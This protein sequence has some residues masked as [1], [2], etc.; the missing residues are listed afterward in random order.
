MPHQSAS[1]R[2][3]VSSKSNLAA[4]FFRYG[5]D[6]ETRLSFWPAQLHLSIKS[7]RNKKVPS[8]KSVNMKINENKAKCKQKEKRQR[9]RPKDLNSDFFMYTSLGHSKIK[10]LICQRAN[11]VPPRT[12]A[13]GAIRLNFCRSTY[14]RAAYLTQRGCTFTAEI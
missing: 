8:E 4:F 7:I 12:W 10:W 13:D 14:T 1:S 3:G 11:L 5:R 6:S 2:A 9:G